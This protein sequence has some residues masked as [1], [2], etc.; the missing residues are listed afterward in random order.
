MNLHQRIM[1]IVDEVKYIQTEKQPQGLTFRPLS[2]QRVVKS[3]RDALIKHGVCIVPGKCQNVMINPYTTTKGS[4]MQLTTINQ[5]YIIFNADDPKEYFISSIPASGSDSGDKGA[6]KAFTQTEKQLFINLFHIEVGDDEH[7]EEEPAEIE[8]IDAEQASQI[9]A[10]AAKAGVA[11]EVICKTMGVDA[12]EKIAAQHF[13]ALCD[14]LNKK[15]E[16]I[17]MQ[18]QKLVKA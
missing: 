10:L 16:M 11:L 8:T 18:S 2:R 1:K 7:T 12:P 15:A 13:D 5:E 4:A 3:V 6:N 14:R 9:V 17:A